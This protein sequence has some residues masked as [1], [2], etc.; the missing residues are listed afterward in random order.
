MYNYINGISSIQLIYI[1]I[2]MQVVQFLI[3]T[4]M[5]E[6]I[7]PSRPPGYAPAR[8]AGSWWM[9]VQCQG[10]IYYILSIYLHHVSFQSEIV[11]KLTFF[12]ILQLLKEQTQQNFAKRKIKIASTKL[13][14]E[15]NVKEF[16]GLFRPL[17][18]TL[19]LSISNCN[20]S[21]PYNY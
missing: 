16:A 7:Q 9:M 4:S 6:Y 20:I 1:L 5:V 12:Q 17:S 18:D 19:C 15:F 21:G 11:R 2:Y 10:L 8:F 14:S 3:Q 13:A